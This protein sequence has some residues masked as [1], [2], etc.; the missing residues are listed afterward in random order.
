MFTTLS[1]FMLRLSISP[2][3]SSEGFL[4]PLT[5][6]CPHMDCQ[7]SLCFLL[8]QSLITHPGNFADIPTPSTGPVSGCE[9]H[10]LAN[11]SAVSFPSISLCPGVHISRILLY[12][13]SYFILKL[14]LWAEINPIDTPVQT[15]YLLWPFHLVLSLAPR[16]SVELLI[17]R[18]PHFFRDRT[19]LKI[20]KLKPVHTLLFLVNHVKCK[21]YILWTVHRDAHGWERPTRCTLFLSNL[22]N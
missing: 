16:W 12:I 10:S 11:S 21:L 4:K 18:A 14:D 7:C 22:F 15:F 2:A 13:Y 19:Q 1:W 9:E 5:C 20:W 3:F 6:L 8:V 17:W